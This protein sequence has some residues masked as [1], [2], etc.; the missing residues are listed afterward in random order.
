M[1]VI[2]NR[3]ASGTVAAPCRALVFTLLCAAT[4]A[5]TAGSMG[6]L[7]DSSG[8]VV[9]AAASGTCVHTSSWSESMAIP[10]CDGFVEKLA[11]ASAGP[12]VATAAEPKRL[13]QVTLDTRALFAFDKAVLLPEAKQALDEM[14][15][16]LNNYTDV[17]KVVIS[18]YTD[19]IGDDAYNK[20][21][22]RRRAQAV[23]DYLATRTDVNRT[24]IEVRAMGEADP[25][26]E[27]QRTGSFRDLVQCLQ[28][29]RRVTVDIS[30][31]RYE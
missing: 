6:Y 13:E 9:Q 5:A 26:V 23:A 21:L 12:M 17:T 11:P 4:G 14:A 16:R 25:V 7:T 20:E 3:P 2:I 22:S 15:Q 29:N 30:A 24:G 10:G 19:R 31:K 18:G 1:S 27:C 8:A 28:P